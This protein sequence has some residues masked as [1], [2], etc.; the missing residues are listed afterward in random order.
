MK[1][2]ISEKTREVEV[3]IKLEINAELDKKELAFIVKKIKNAIK[4]QKYICAFE[5]LEISKIPF[6]EFKM[7]IGLAEVICKGDKL[8]TEDEVFKYVK[9]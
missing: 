2:N 4:T 1:L 8:K 5:I 9:K 6:Q 7:K 3:T